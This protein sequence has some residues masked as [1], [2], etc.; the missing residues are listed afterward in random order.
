MAIRYYDGSRSKGAEEVT[1]KLREA[2]E[3]IFQYAM[4]KNITPEEFC[5]LTFEEADLLGLTY[6][7]HKYGG[8]KGKGGCS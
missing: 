4:E 5:Y 1:K 7:R 2:M 6:N 8:G 3:P